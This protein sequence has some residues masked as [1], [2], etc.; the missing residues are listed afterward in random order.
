VK[1]TNVFN[2]AL[3][4]SFG[5]SLPAPGSRHL[6]HDYFP[7]D[8]VRVSALRGNIRGGSSGSRSRTDRRPRDNMRELRRS[9]DGS[10]GAVPSQI[11]LDRASETARRQSLKTQTPK[12]AEQQSK[13]PAQL[14][15]PRL[16]TARLG[17]VDADQR[18]KRGQCDRAFVDLNKHDTR[19]PLPRE[20]L[21][22]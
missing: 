9:A 4:R 2:S 10:C 13:Q 15:R 14:C 16:S 20:R 19:R 11:F 18:S 21:T 5:A 22:E 6:A 7:I 12:S 17:W 8:I 1:W 3:T